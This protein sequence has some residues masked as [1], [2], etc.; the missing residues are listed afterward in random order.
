[1]GKLSALGGLVTISG[2]VLLIF[3]VVGSVTGRDLP[4]VEKA[5]IDIL[6]PDFID[7]IDGMQSG[8]FQMIATSAVELPIYMHLIIIGIILLLVSGLVSK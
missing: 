8:F 7:K 6:N 1:M 4:M 2:L 5:L 3:K